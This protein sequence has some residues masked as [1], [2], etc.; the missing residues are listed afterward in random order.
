MF[1]N[2][3]RNPTVKHHSTRKECQVIVSDIKGQSSTRTWR[4]SKALRSSYTR[5]LYD[6]EK[7]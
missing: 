4:I 2:T 6:V 7:N 1:P 5:T 3:G